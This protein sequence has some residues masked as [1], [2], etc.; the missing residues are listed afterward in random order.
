MSHHP[1]LA[2]LNAAAAI[3]QLV[4]DPFLSLHVSLM[5]MS[6]RT[7]FHFQSVYWQRYQ[8]SSGQI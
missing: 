2:L 7:I 8:I 3:I 6:C 4:A 1:Y 5:S